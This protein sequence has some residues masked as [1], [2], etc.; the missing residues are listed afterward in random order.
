MLRGRAA[1]ALLLPTALWAVAWCSRRGKS[2]VELGRDGVEA[3]SGA[4]RDFLDDDE[5]VEM[6]ELT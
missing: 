5:R 4:A 3:L 6:L 2:T 1:A